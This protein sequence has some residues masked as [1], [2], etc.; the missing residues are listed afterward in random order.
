MCGKRRGLM[1]WVDAPPAGTRVCGGFDGS[2]TGDHTVIKLETV[3]GLLFTPRYGPDDRPTVWDPEQWG[4]R[5][6][7]GEVHA[8]WEQIAG[9]YRLERVYC[10]PWHFQSEIASWGQLYGEDV[11][12]E[13]HTNRDRAMHEALE[14]FFTDVDAGTLRHDGCPLT[15][16]HMGNARRVARPGARYGLAKPSDTQKIDAA[17]TSVI[18]HKAAT[19]ARATGWG[20]NDDVDTRVFCFR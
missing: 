14:T 13:W 1:R 11:F 2:T 9:T 20:N 8:A 7:R 19:D 4:G 12:I 10:D 16:L 3:D 5:V 17:V 6:P 18:A 15:N